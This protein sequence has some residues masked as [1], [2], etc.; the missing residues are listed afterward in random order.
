M[1]GEYCDCND[2]LYK[3]ENGCSFCLN[4]SCKKCK[5]STMECSNKFYLIKMFLI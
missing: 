4:K 5:D 2:G 1:F 3:T